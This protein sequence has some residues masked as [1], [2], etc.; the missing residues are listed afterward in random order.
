MA[1]DFVDQFKKLWSNKK[2]DESMGV[3]LM[4]WAS[5]KK[6]NIHNMN[7]VNK[8]LKWVN[9]NVY[10]AELSL[11]NELR[12]FIRSPSTNK[13]KEDLDFFYSD[14]CEYYGWTRRELEKNRFVVDWAII[15]GE[16][17]R[18]YAYDSKQ[19]KRLSKRF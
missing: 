17:A 11:L 8:H 2:V 4:I 16:V 19:V 3:G 12:G 18:A 9:R 13:Q 1:N 6:E 7:Q 15:K 10:I 14:V 5:G